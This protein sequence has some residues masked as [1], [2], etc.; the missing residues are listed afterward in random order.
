MWT[1]KLLSH[2]KVSLNNKVHLHRKHFCRPLSLA[3]QNKINK[4]FLF[5]ILIDAEN[6][7]TFRAFDA[8]SQA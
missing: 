8:R 7:G 3:K 2:L 4:R 5:Q 1:E 6:I